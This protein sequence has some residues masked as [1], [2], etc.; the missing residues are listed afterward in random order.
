MKKFVIIIITVA[1]SISLLGTAS[2]TEA[3][4]N[5]NSFRGVWIATVANIDYPAKPTVDSN[6]LKSEAIKILN[7]VKKLKLNAVFLQVRPT[8]DAIYPSKIFPWSK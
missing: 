5:S 1:L 2:K 6:K 4:S 3:V 7:E 8:S